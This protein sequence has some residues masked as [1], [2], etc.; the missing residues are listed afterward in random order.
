MDL[1]RHPIIPS[2]GNASQE[3]PEPPNL[4]V[5]LF[6][7]GHFFYH[8]LNIFFLQLIHRLHRIQFDVDLLVVFQINLELLGK[9]LSHHLCIHTFFVGRNIL[10]FRVCVSPDGECFIG[11]VLSQNRCRFGMLVV[12]FC[13]L[14]QSSESLFGCFIS[15]IF[16]TVFL[17]ILSRGINSKFLGNEVVSC[18][19]RFDID[20]LILKGFSSG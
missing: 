6:V 20:D 9:L 16:D 11:K 14:F 15:W 1:Q 13:F 3:I 5:T 4:S 18:I 19:S 2:Q 8:F 12:F 10:G 7:R 17:E